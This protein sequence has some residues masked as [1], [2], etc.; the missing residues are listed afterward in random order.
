MCGHCN[1]CAGHLLANVI[2]WGAARFLQPGMGW[3]MV[4]PNQ[5]IAGPTLFF[6]IAMERSVSFPIPQDPSLAGMA[7]G[8]QGLD[9]DLGTGLMQTTNRPWAIV[10]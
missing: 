3:V 1:A 10:Q 5:S 9:I 7:L 4:D 8:V 6:P 2:S